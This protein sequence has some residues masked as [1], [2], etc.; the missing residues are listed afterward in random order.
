MREFHSKKSLIQIPL[1][2]LVIFEN[3][4]DV[5]LIFASANVHIYL[6]RADTPLDL[7]DVNVIVYVKPLKSLEIEGT[8]QTR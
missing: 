1:L 4:G 3:S 7:Q 8:C 5:S 6:L 2:E